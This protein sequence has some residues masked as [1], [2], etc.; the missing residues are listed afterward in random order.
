VA[1]RYEVRDRALQFAVRDEAVL[2]YEVRDR[3]ALQ[4]AVRDEVAPR[5]AVRDWAAPVCAVLTVAAYGEQAQPFLAVKPA[6][7]GVRQELCA[8]A[9]RPLV[10]L[11]LV[12][13][14]LWPVPG[15]E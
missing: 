2:P 5:Y 13:M 6:A 1:P 15:Q 4:L 10:L 9:L 7:Q 3:A 12:Q 14:R 8:A 11:V